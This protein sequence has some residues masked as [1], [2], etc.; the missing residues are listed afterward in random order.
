M[1]SKLMMPLVNISRHFDNSKYTVYVLA[2]L[3]LHGE[4]SGSVVESST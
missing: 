3:S 4:G 2:E 1:V